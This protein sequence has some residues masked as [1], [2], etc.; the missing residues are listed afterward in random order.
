MLYNKPE[1]PTPISSIIEHSQLHLRGKPG[2][3]AQSIIIKCNTQGP[4]SSSACSGTPCL[5]HG[6]ISMGVQLCLGR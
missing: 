1:K 2:S 3:Q 6:Y 4:P 5:K